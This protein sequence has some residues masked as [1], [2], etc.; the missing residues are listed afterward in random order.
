VLQH[1]STLAPGA[2]DG[3]DVS[4]A[5]WAVLAYLNDVR[6]EP[7]QPEEEMPEGFDFESGGDLGYSLH[8]AF[9]AN[10]FLLSEELSLYCLA[11]GEVVKVDAPSWRESS[12]D[13]TVKI[14]SKKMRKKGGGPVVRRESAVPVN[15]FFRIFTAAEEEDGAGD[16]MPVPEL[17]EEIVM[18]LREDAIPRA[19]IY[20]MQ[21]L[22]GFD[23]EDFDEEGGALGEDWEAPPHQGRQSR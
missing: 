13:P 16:V 7:W 11:N 2:I 19:A 8:F 5:D 23:G 14:V 15:S 6:M 20:Y 21:A 17:Q 4:D 1:S 9:A 3:F 18:R 12:R 22:H 10:P